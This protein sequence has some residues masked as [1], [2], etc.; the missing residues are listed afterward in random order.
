VVQSLEALPENMGLI[1]ASMLELTAA[2]HSS[3]RRSNALFWPPEALHSSGAQKHLQVKQLA[4][5]EHTLIYLCVCVCVCVCMYMYI[6]INL[7]LILEFS[8]K[9]YVTPA[10]L[11]ASLDSR[12]T[13]DAHMIYTNPYT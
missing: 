5:S 9:L 11:L 7:V 6:C 12:Y 2:C 3:L 10:P 1:L 8:S 13:H 4:L